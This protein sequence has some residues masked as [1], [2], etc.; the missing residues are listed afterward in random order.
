MSVHL[1][2]VTRQKIEAF[3]RRRR[4][5]VMGRGLCAGVFS[6]LATMT[7]VALLDYLFVLSDET[8]WALSMTA[9]GTIILVTWWLWIRLLM[10]VPNERQ[11][12]RLIEQS[13][14]AL[15]EDLLSAV[16]LGADDADATLD[17]P[18]FRSLL[19][20]SVARRIRGVHTEALLPPRLIRRWIT[21]PRAVD[22]S[23]QIIVR[24]VR[25]V[26]GKCVRKSEIVSH[27]VRENVAAHVIR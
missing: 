7:A 6:L 15:R 4:R 21:R 22:H 9:Y 2:P 18:V 13:E 12:A 8:R 11:L 24:I 17:S 19:Q 14:P 20:A 23:R 3:A 10:R 5:L 27:L 16:E 1:D 25:I 26:I